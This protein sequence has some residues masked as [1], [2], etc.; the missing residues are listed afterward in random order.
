VNRT[1]Q[2]LRVEIEFIE[3]PDG[4][5]DMKFRNLNKDLGR[6]PHQHNQVMQER[7]S[8]SEDTIRKMDTSV[9]ENIK[10]KKVLIQ[11]FQE[12]WNIVR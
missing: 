9:K 12:I 1:V 2:D 8:D 6:E 11:N 5:L 10:S 3:K 7:F 4:N